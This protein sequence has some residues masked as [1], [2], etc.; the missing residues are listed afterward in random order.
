MLR[1]EWGLTVLKA[2][3]KRRFAWI[4]TD[5]R[6]VNKEQEDNTHFEKNLFHVE[7]DYIIGLRLSID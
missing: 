3:R 5:T 4:N 6:T 7:Q 1:G 2:L